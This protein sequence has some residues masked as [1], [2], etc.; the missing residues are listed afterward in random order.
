VSDLDRIERYAT[1]ALNDA[2]SLRQSVRLIRTQPN[3]ETRA[4]DAMKT[5]ETE[6]SASLDA[7]RQALREFSTK[8]VTA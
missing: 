1:R 4:E 5:A 7:V 2:R 8:P 6:L 3:F